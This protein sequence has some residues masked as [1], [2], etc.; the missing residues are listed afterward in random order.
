MTHPGESVSGPPTGRGGGRDAPPL[1]SRRRSIRLALGG[2]AIAALALIWLAA[3]RPP[4]PAEL[5]RLLQ[6]A[7]DAHRAGRHD[8]AEAL[9]DRVASSREPTPLDRLLRA[10]VQL[11]TDRPEQARDQLA[12]IPDDHPIA[13]IS[14]LLL[15]QVEMR[16]GRVPEAERSFLAAVRL[17]PRHVQAHRELSFIYSIQRRLRELDEQLAALASLG[18][19]PPSYVLHWSKIRNVNWNYEKDLD[20]LRRFL[21]GDPGDRHSRLT[22]AEAIRRSGDLNEA[23][24][25]LTP[26]PPTDPDAAALRA[27][28]AIEGGDLTRAE[29]MIARAPADHPAVA[30]VRGEIELI[31]GDPEAALPHLRAAEQNDPTDRLVNF[32]LGRALTMLGRAEEAAPYLDRVRRNDALGQLISRASTLPDLD[33]PDLCVEIGRACLSLGRSLE[34]RAWFDTALSVDP[35]HDEAQE[36]IARIEAGSPGLSSPL[37]A[38]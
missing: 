16:L 33:D 14:R 7:Q 34:A 12:R 18:E 11:A 20:N 27:G 3:A 25:I 38:S 8:R 21:A 10:Q 13:P 19:L 6:L 15:G 28:M 26:L 17:Q 30:R 36:S 24:R 23:G 1:P 9:L 32:H 22:L 31:R 29:E 2:A 5:D 35:F 37:D 4:S